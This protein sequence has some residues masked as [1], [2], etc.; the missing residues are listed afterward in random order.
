MSQSNPPSI[1]TA[2]KMLT[3]AMVL[4]LGRNICATREGSRSHLDTVSNGTMPQL[5][6]HCGCD[7]FMHGVQYFLQR[8]RLL[9]CMRGEGSGDLKSSPPSR[10]GNN[11]D[12]GKRAPQLRDQFQ[13]IHHRHLHVGND[14]VSWLSLV[15]QKSF[16]AVLG[17]DDIV[18]LELYHG[19]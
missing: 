9:K 17:L 15:T 7:E 6:G 5:R 14:Q 16:V 12:P 19:S 1:N 11:L 4:V 3:R 2:P 8:K 10:D 18:S 13:T